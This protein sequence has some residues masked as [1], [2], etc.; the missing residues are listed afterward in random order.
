MK[1]FLSAPIHH[2]G[3]RVGNFYLSGREGDPEFTEEDEGM[4][5]LVAAQAALALVNT[6]PVGVV[7][8]DAGTGAL[9]WINR[10]ARRIVDGLRN[11]EQSPERFLEALIFRSLAFAVLL[12]MAVAAGISPDAEDLQ[13]LL[14][15]PR[16]QQPPAPVGHW[17]GQERPSASRARP[18]PLQPSVYARTKPSCAPRRR[19][20]V[21]S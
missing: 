15:F 4:L 19:R 12:P 10:E 5:A 16:H 11:P 21:A 20:P 7:V 6:S 17:P 18:S 8:L 3:L 14:T 2:L 13:P 1:A 9:S